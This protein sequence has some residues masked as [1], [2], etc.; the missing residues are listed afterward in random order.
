MLLVSLLLRSQPIGS[1]Q[2]RDAEACDLQIWYLQLH[3][4]VCLRVR[5]RWWQARVAIRVREL[6]LFVGLARDL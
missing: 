4:H 2:S 5:Y 6:L 1:L 3:P